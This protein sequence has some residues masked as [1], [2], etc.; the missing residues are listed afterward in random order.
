VNVVKQTHR[1][2]IIVSFSPR[3]GLTEEQGAKLA[4]KIINQTLTREEAVDLG[5]D[6]VEFRI[7]GTEFDNPYVRAGD[8]VRVVAFE[9]ESGFTGY[10]DT[11]IPEPAPEKETQPELEPVPTEGSYCQDCGALRQPGMK[12]CSNC[13]KETD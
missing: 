6:D 4:L 11:P 2:E 5:L 8:P 3:P 1:F 13:G 9:P 10:P 7:N 12:F